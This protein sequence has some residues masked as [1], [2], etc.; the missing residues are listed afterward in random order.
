MIGRLLSAGIR[1]RWEPSLLLF[2]AVSAAAGAAAAT[3][4]LSWRIDRTTAANL[5]RSGP[6]LVMRP[7]LE[8]SGFFTLRDLERVRSLP[9]VRTAVPWSH[10]GN[11]AGAE[12]LLTTSAAL[13]LYP[14]WELTGRWPRDPDERI[15]GA[16]TTPSTDSVGVLTTGERRFDRA[17]LQNLEG[18]PDVPIQRIEVRAAPEMLGSVRSSLQRRL[19]GA[20]VV[21]VARV[22]ETETALGHRLVVLL[23]SISGVI[24]LLALGT[25]VAAG[26]TE[27]ESR[28][29]EIALLQSLGYEASWIRRLLGLELGVIGL[30][31]TVVG[32]LAGELLAAR[33]A[34]DLLGTGGWDPSL[35]V[36]VLTGAATLFLLIATVLITGR[37]LGRL[38]PA[39]ELKNR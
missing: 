10:T 6:N 29:R 28:R 8:G 15:R 9:G 14:H 21:P 34:R 13:D 12:I 11:D 17:L 24:L 26:L 27:V 35:V 23:G 22:T 1:H 39:V 38:N 3:A 16:A 30:V 37:R 7:Q 2:L 32:F 5:E 4:G 31:A 36:G 19:P 33:L 18:R 25:V 20:E